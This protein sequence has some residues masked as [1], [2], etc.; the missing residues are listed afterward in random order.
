MIQ[1]QV[2][3]NNPRVAMVLARFYPVLGGTEKQ[4]LLLA[5]HLQ[6]QGT[7]LFIVT[8]RLPR[9]KVYEE[10]NTVKIYRT[11]SYFTGLAGSVCFMFSAALLLC[12]RRKQFDLIQVFLAGSPALM[13]VILGWLLRKK[14]VLKLGGAGVTG[15]IATS[16]SSLWGH[17][18]LS[19]LKK[20]IPAFIVPSE[21]VKKELAVAG[22]PENRIR[23]IPNGVD[24]TCFKQVEKVKKKELREKLALPM[25]MLS[26][27]TGRM[28]PGKGLETLLSAWELVFHEVPL[29][30]LL[31]VGDGSLRKSLIDSLSDKTCRQ[32]V[33]FTGTV[34]NV[35][36]YL[37]AADI[38]ILPSLA[39][40]LSNSLL[41]AMSSG[42]AVVAS[43]I[44][45]IN[46]LVKNGVNGLLAE[47]GDPASLSCQLVSLLRAP[48]EINRLGQEAHQTIIKNYSIENVTEQYN[49][50]Y[51]EL[52]ES[53]FDPHY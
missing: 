42:L 25:P 53:N 12:R 21:V 5:E 26:I 36:D 10:I 44:G 37:Q 14:V 4:A 46:E 49:N 16:Q 35:A 27:Y 9:L 17:W 30:Y 6:R 51:Q 50:L 3:Q 39:E 19:W 41:E 15:D 24:L 52:K 29:A 40:G 38:F 47:P 7:E 34:D 11:A 22:F 43:D 8:A 13:A 20:Y 18:K 31:L 33:I 32:Q 1:L 23:L 2:E 48:G 28:E 45:G